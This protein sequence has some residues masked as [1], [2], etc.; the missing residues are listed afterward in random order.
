MMAENLN[1]FIIKKA[2][3]RD[4]LDDEKDLIKDGSKD[5]EDEL[6]SGSIVIKKPMTKIDEDEHH[7]QKIEKIDMPE[8]RLSNKDTT[9]M[10]RGDLY[11]ADLSP[12]IGSEQGGIRPVVIIQ[13]DIGNKFSPTTIIAAITSVK[14]K[15][16]MPTHVNVG[17]EIGGLPK[18]S[19][20][21][22]EQIRTIDKR[23]IREKI[24]HFNDDMILK[25]NQALK[26][27]VDL[28]EEK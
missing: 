11:Y 24:G 3:A 20:I 25:I 19:V 8:R 1:K 4:E 23:R 5:A 14:N 26:V 16:N 27:S 22:L 28:V 6:N 12:V 18:D 21:L 13:N 2:P 9:P 15:S 17:K 10:L 7:R